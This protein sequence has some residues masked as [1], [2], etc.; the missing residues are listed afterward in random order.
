MR[1]ESHDGN[2]GTLAV[3][4]GTDAWTYYTPGVSFYRFA[5]AVTG[6]GCGGSL[7]EFYKLDDNP[8]SAA[9]IGRDQV[10]LTEGLQECE[11][12]RT[13][14]NRAPAPG[15]AGAHSVRTICIDP[16]R[17][18]VLRDSE[19]AETTSGMRSS[20]TTTYTRSERDPKLPADIFEF[21][22]PTGTFE[23]EGPQL[24]DGEPIA[25]SGVYRMGP[26]VSGP[27]LFTRSS[28]PIR[29]K[30]VRREFRE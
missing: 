29:R 8:E 17:H 10:Q 1:R 5:Q 18:F 26:R 22:V 11:V 27:R 7:A 15:A 23:D 2:S 19:T 14:W 21:S 24:D 4:D 12:V 20:K 30:P 3:C 9:V 16:V 25:E 28:L 6:N 13:E